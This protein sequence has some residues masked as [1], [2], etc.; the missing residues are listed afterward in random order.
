MLRAAVVALLVIGACTQ[1][2]GSASAGPSDAEDRAQERLHMVRKQIEAR[3]VRDPRVLDAMRTVPRHRF[4]PESQRSA[5]YDDRPLPIGE[6]Q[7]ISQPYIVALMSELADLEP[8]D[9]VLEVG[10]GSG[11]QA[12][13]LAEMGVKVYSIEIVEPLAKRAKAILDELG[14]GKR[15]EVRHGDG[16][17]GWP[18]RAPFDAVIVTAAPPKI[19]EPL[20]QQLEVGGR[21]IIPVGKHFQSLLRVTR[22]E[23]GFR[24]E[25]VIPVRFVPMTGKAQ[26]K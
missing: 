11:Y 5:A 18:E 10:T 22:T 12:A 2:S 8:G 21:L 16:Y 14:Y 4:M 19:P 24:E 3:G 23:D 13:V 1:T 25:S 9:E 26:E 7:T 6:G 15:V 17:A 20:K